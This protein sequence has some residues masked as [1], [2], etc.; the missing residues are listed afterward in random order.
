MPK[1]PEWRAA[2]V[3]IETERIALQRDVIRKRMIAGEPPLCSECDDTGFAKVG[4][5]FKRCDCRELRR[6]EVLGRRPM[7]ALPEAGPIVNHEPKLLEA[8]KDAVK[9]MP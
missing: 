1:A 6:L 8:V 3:K 4:Q 9:G 7:P 2:V 5:R